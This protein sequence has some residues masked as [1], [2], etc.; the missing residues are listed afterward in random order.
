MDASG[1][2]S[3]SGGSGDGGGREGRNTSKPTTPQAPHRTTVD[4]V[5]AALQAETEMTKE[6]AS[7]TSGVAQGQP[8]PAV[9]AAELNR[10]LEARDQPPHLLLTE[11]AAAEK[12]EVVC[13]A[14]GSEKDRDAAA[15][16][17]NTAGEATKR[18]RKRAGPSSNG[19]STDAPPESSDSLDNNKHAPCLVV[20]G[21]AMR[22]FREEA[23]LKSVELVQSRIP[24]KIIHVNNM[25]QVYGSAFGAVWQQNTFVLCMNLTLPTSHE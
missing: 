24:A 21:P 12:E 15:A 20:E 3:L 18:K 16:P 9:L 23:R 10:E 1:H 2:K 8:A 5:L 4:E 14:A 13:S 7:F 22:A 17:G 11:V 19:R 6:L 25:F